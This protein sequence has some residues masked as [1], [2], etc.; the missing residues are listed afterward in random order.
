MSYII[1]VDVDGV[2]RDFSLDLY[3]VI[4]K[5]YPKFIRKGSD[6][7][8]SVEET[9]V[10]WDLEHCYQGTNE[11]IQKIYREEHA[12][13]ILGNGTEFKSEVDYLREQIELGE[14]KFVCITSQAP[15][16]R[17]W[18]LKW[19]GD[20]GLN[21]ETV[22]FRRGRFK[23]TVQCD[24]LIDDSPA[25]YHFWKKNRKD[26][27]GYMLINQAWNQDIETPNRVNGIEEAMNIIN[28]K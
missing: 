14:H 12:E 1:G 16:C 24:F 26:D 5:N 11:E 23:W 6:G 19:L 2:L 27:K 20:R 8:Y 17:Y 25:N 18:T 15:I 22:Y 7:V 3:K 10:H 28:G 9:S 4:E 13:T 21:F